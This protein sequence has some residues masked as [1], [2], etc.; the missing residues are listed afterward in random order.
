ML[1]VKNSACR[2]VFSSIGVA[3]FYV[4]GRVPLRMLIPT[5][6]LRPWWKLTLRVTRHLSLL[7][8][9]VVIPP[10]QALKFQCFSLVSFCHNFF[11][12]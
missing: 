7:G 5:L 8:G 3:N 6:G 12:L 11:D 2:A 10:F 4:S 9:V 1:N